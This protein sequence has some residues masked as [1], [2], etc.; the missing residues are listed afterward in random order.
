[1]AR[2]RV[3][4]L[5]LLAVLVLLAVAVPPADAL[6]RPRRKRPPAAAGAVNV[7]AEL[8]RAR[9]LSP[10][11]INVLRPELVDPALWQAKKRL[12]SNPPSTVV[13]AEPMRVAGP[14]VVIKSFEIK[15]V[16]GEESWQKGHDTFDTVLNEM[17]ITRKMNGLPFMVRFLGGVHKKRRDPADRSKLTLEASIFL[18]KAKG[19]LEDRALRGPLDTSDDTRKMLA[20][21]VVAV[22]I[23]HWRGYL[24][25]DL[26]P[27]QF[28]FGEDDV[29]RLAD[30]GTSIKNDREVIWQDTLNRIGD[31]GY[32]GLSQLREATANVVLP[33]KGSRKPDN[34]FDN[35]AYR[36]PES[37]FFIEI[38]KLRSNMVEAMADQAVNVWYTTNR[39]DI[40]KYKLK[41][42]ERAAIR[43]DLEPKIRRAARALDAQL[44]ALKQRSYGKGLD[45]YALGMT[46]WDL[47]TGMGSS[48]MPRVLPYRNTLGPNSM[49]IIPDFS[50]PLDLAALDRTVRDPAARAAL[51]DLI[52]RL[53]DFDPATRLQDAGA[54]LSHRF[55]ATAGVRLADL[56]L[57]GMKAAADDNRAPGPL[58]VLAPRAGRGGRGAETAATPARGAK[59][60]GDALDALDLDPQGT[61]G[62]EDEP[63][64]A[65][66]MLRGDPVG[67]AAIDTANAAVRALGGKKIIDVSEGEGDDEDNRGAQRGKMDGADSEEDGGGADEGEPEDNGGPGGEDGSEGSGS[68]GGSGMGDASGKDDGS[69]GFGIDWSGR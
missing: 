46:L 34:T 7:E 29:L 53:L 69:E 56:L 59:N 5:L 22:A 10:K 8:A 62:L 61:K 16:K 63:R 27:S 11:K 20:Q 41:A 51:K 21:M 33:G 42:A 68:N 4:L 37:L 32:K 57:V 40:N 66:P 18:A 17:A 2:R 12:S 23:L 3:P 15:V 24:H 45:Y 39:K 26:K 50:A 14:A 38:R 49:S 30:F 44:A 58:G 65:L 6:G 31:V 48:K 35:E 67:K 36:S 52:A 43:A 28:L 13:I 55:F 64:A 25:R 60:L 9:F 47:Y 1:M 54:V 19:T